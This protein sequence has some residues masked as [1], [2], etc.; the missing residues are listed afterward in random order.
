MVEISETGTEI[1]IDI[2]IDIVIDEKEDG[3]ST[4]YIVLI[5]VISVLVLIIL[6]FFTLRCIKKRQDIDFNKKAQ[7]ITQEKLLNDM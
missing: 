7:E 6:V 1:N 4:G 5:S 3:L 2:D